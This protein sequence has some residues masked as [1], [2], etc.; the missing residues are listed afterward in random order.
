MLATLIM[1]G[2][3]A[4][5]TQTA[6]GRRSR[7]IRSATIRCSRRF[8]SLRSSCSP[9]WS[10]TA[11]SELRR[12]EPARATVE[13]PAPERRS[14]SSGSRRRKLPRACRSRSRS[15]RELLAHRAEQGRRIVGGAGADDHLASQTTLLIAVAAE[16]CSVAVE[17]AA[18]KSPRR[19]GAADLRVA[20]RMRDRAS[21]AVIATQPGQ[22]RRRPLQPRASTSSPGE[23]N[24][25]DRE[26]A[27]APR[28]GRS[29]AAAG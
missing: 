15:S 3:G 23:T 5:S 11:G 1:T 14:S 19:A 12:V 10:S 24:G 29:R 25:V 22:A 28:C 16:S 26:E 7:T 21:A 20:G 9:R 27:R 2:S 4:A 17:T 13:T 6:C 18:S 8:L